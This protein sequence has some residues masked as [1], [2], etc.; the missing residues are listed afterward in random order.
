MATTF[1]VSAHLDDRFVPAGL[2][3]M[4][5]TGTEVLTSGFRYGTTYSL[6]HLALG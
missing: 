3:S 1:A 4:T 6:S 2:L 5:E